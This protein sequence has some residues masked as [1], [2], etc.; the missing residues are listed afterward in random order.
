MTFLSVTISNNNRSAQK[1]SNIIISTKK[2]IKCVKACTWNSLN[3]TSDVHDD[4]SKLSTTIM[5]CIQQ[6]SYEQTFFQDSASPWITIGIS[7]SCN[8]KCLV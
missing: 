7:N 5:E 2:L 1:Q 3:D 6:S 8:F 4:C